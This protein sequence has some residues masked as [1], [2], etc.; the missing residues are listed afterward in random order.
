MKHK[1][2]NSAR[3]ILQKHIN[4]NVKYKKNIFAKYIFYMP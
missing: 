2:F 4:Y 1:P 3:L